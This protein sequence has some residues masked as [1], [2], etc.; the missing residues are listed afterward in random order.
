MRTCIL[1]F[2]VITVLLSSCKTFQLSSIPRGTAMEEK[3]PPLEPDFDV[4]SF[5]PD[6]QDLYN[7][8]NI[9]VSGR[10]PNVQNV[11]NKAT[12]S[13]TIAEDTK[14]IYNRT[15][16]D[17]MTRSVG[18]TKGFIVCRLGMRTRSFDSNVNPIVSALTL[19]VMNIFGYKA[20]TYRDEMEIIVDVYD[21]NNEIVG[22]FS[23][24]GVGKADVK[25]YNG[26]NVPSA[27][28]TAHAKAFTNAMEIIAKKM[29]SEVGALKMRLQG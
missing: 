28:R 4:S 3:L 29:Q 5:G 18:E 13:L 14:R 12:L 7:I 27:K 15:I 21:L 10:I 24:L 11:V 17:R 23:A 26:Y 16:I 8:P 1:G 19:G 25:L 22:S 6:Y 2:V 20:A 9:I